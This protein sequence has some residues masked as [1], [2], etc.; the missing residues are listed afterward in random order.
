MVESCVTKRA[1]A[2]GKVLRVGLARGWLAER[3]GSEGTAAVAAAAAALQG[4]GATLSDWDTAAAEAGRAAAFLITNSESAAFHLDRLRTR[5]A[6]YDPDTRDRFFAG[7]LLPA[8]WVARAQRVRQSWLRKTQETFDTLAVL[9]LPATPCAAPRRGQQT[10]EIAG[11]TVAVRPNLCLLAQPISCIGLP[12]VT[13][14]IFSVGDLPIGIQIVAPPWKE[15]L[16]PRVAR[17][18]ERAEL[19][20]AH[21]PRLASACRFIGAAVFKPAGLW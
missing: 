4:E 15:A 20:V 5:A 12:V 6:E 3:S 1:E 13:A 10:M 8:A 21:P 19:A 2:T 11:R 9:L 16:A 14:R 17:A 18:L 7:A